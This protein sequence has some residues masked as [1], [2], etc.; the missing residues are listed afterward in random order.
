MICLQTGC[1]RLSGGSPRCKSHWY[2]IAVKQRLAEDRRDQVLGL[3]KARPYGA[4]TDGGA[5]RGGPE[6]NPLQPDSHSSTPSLVG[7]LCRCCFT[8]KTHS[9]R[10]YYWGH[11]VGGMA[12]QG[13]HFRC[14]AVGLNSTSPAGWYTVGSVMHCMLSDL[15]SITSMIWTILVCD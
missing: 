11:S 9:L 5:G 1:E 15:L 7:G 2:E 6:T 13:D 4:V 12:F 3:G 14:G 8:P 10:L